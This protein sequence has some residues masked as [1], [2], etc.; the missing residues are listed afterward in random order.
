MP[1]VDGDDAGNN[2]IQHLRGLEHGPAIVLQWRNG[3]T[4]EDA[5]GWVLKGHDAGV[6]GD[7][8]SRI[9]REFASIDEL[10]TLFKVKTGP[11]RLKTDYLA[12]E[13][14]AAVIGS[15]AACR[16]RALALLEAVTRA[17][18]GQQDGCAL[19]ERDAANSDEQCVVLRLSP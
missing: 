3:W 17:C 16:E 5:I 12:F 11:G 15:Q 8:R 6:L 1:L 19:L 7:L 9:D 13:A 18:L 14:V 10:V 2:K 4:I